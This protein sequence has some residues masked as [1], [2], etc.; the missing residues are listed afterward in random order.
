MHSP[1]NPAPRTTVSRLT[2]AL[3]VTLMVTLGSGLAGSAVAAPPAPLPPAADA[4][5]AR[6]SQSAA[7]HGDTDTQPA[8]GSGRTD[9]SDAAGQSRQPVVGWLELSGR[10]REG[11]VPFAWVNKADVQ[12]SLRDVIHQL[13]RVASGEHYLGVVLFLDQPRLSLTQAGEIA[14]AIQQVRDA[15]KKVFTFAEQYD[16][17]TYMMASAADKI[18]L[19]HHGR[20]H[21]RGLSMEEMYV[22]GLLE[23][24]GARADLM[25]VGR[26]KGAKD[27]LTR[28]S[29]SPGWNQ[30]MNALL[31]DLYDQIVTRIA[32]G[33]DMTRQELERIMADSWTMN[34]GAYLKRNVIDRLADRDLVQVTQMAFGNNFVWDDQLGLAQESSQPAQSPFAL[35]QTLFQ[36][37]E[38]KTQRQSIAVIHAYGPVTSGKSSRGDG[39]FAARS[40]GSKTM[41]KML[42]K[43]R[44][45]P[46]I[47]GAVI[48]IDSPGGSALASEVIWQSVKSVAEKK[49]VFVSI[50]GLAASGGYYIASA[51]DEIYVPPQAMLGSIGVVGGKIVLGGVYEK[52]D[53]NVHRRN[54]GPMADM[55]NSVEPFTDKQ[56]EAMR[57]SLQRVYAQFTDRVEHGRGARIDDIEKL[58]KGRVFTGRQAVE[59]GLADQLGGLDET[60]VAAARRADLKKGQYDIIHLPP[61]MSLSEFFNSMFGAQDQAQSRARFGAAARPWLETARQTLGPER[62]QAARRILSG[63]LMLRDQPALTLMPYAIVTR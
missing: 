2:G 15:G 11:P 28:R 18:L 44:D 3:A 27:S 58:A 33:R 60:I 63:L 31:D 35:F 20:V 37:P 53:V 38:K 48:R 6:V 55:F 49:P 59:N 29:P 17:L 10:L 41:I 22:A 52:L 42:G 57:R 5:V 1:R 32:K 56:R 9:Q 50:A 23:K 8:S 34:D 4:S 14:R 47:K 25:Q 54:R 26:F 39:P 12:P 21:L 36:K 19:Q 51:A 13:E 46:L 40:I 16:L 7:P 30:N 24:V 43:V 45:D 61:A 62:W